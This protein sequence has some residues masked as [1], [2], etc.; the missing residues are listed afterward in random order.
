MLLTEKNQ[1]HQLKRDIAQ[2]IEL[3]KEKTGEFQVN[4]EETETKINELKATQQETFE[5]SKSLRK[6]FHDD[7]DKYF[8][9][10]TSA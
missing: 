7:I 9:T 3:L 4:A 10:L 5:T 2:N 8:A 6:A 1:Q